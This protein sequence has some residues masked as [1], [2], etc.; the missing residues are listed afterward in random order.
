MIE[1]FFGFTHVPFTKYIPVDSLYRNADFDEH[2]S[3]LLHIAKT[4][5]FGVVIGDSGVGKS[6]LLRNF[7]E[8]INKSKYRVLYVSDSKITPAM[9]YKVLLE[10]LGFQPKGGAVSDRKRQLHREIA[11]MRGV[12]GVKLVVIVDEAHLLDK[13][14]LEEIRFLLNFKM[15]S[16][17]PTALILCGQSELWDNKLKLQSYAAI[18]QR[19]DFQCILGHHDR[20]RTEEYIA[21]H[22]AYAGADRQIFTDKAIDEIQRYS[23]GT[24]RLINRV[25]TSSLMYA[26]QSRK[27]LID[28]HMV[29]LVV[30]AELSGGVSQ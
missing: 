27:Q 17:N 4:Q 30:E 11:V 16:E 1:E 28:D 8:Q 15:D 12:E 3:R 24:G 25:C 19:I 13:T 7:C 5:Q 20:A 14:M 6:T 23:A 9:F 26:E 29:K 21:A 18:R 10:Q 22:L 2:T